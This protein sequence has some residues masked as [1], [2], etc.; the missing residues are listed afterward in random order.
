MTL[1]SAITWNVDPTFFTLFGLDIRYYGVLWAV[2]FML[3][4]YYF[5][6]FCKHE[7]LPDKLVDSMFWCATI[8]AIVGARLG[9]CLFYEPEVYLADPLRI[10]NIREGGMASHGAAIGFLLG[11]TIFAIANKMPWWWGADRIMI[12]VAIGGAGVRI[13][14]LMNSEIYGGP[15]DLPWGFIF[16]RAGETQPMHPTQIYEALCYIL[17]FVILLWLYFKRDAGRK[18]PGLMFGVGLIGIFV[19]RFIIEYIKNDQVGFEEGMRSAIG[20]N[21]GQLL[22]IPFVVIGIVLVI[23]G[24]LNK[25]QHIAWVEAAKAAEAKPKAKKVAPPKA[26][27]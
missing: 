27:K 26:K 13:G 24:L 22:S 5:T 6:K 10:L 15:T 20:M 3:G 2:A 16:Q 9:H 25:P 4:I 1:F 23:V 11:L 19:A 8:L 7:G 21:M 14:N 17:V 12:P 18:H